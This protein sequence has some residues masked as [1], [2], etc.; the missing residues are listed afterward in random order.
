MTS[1]TLIQFGFSAWH[2]M[3]IAAERMLLGKLP[4]ERGVYCIRCSSSALKLGPSDIVYFGKAENAAGI[5]RRIRQYFHPGHKN[6]TSIR[7]KGEI[8]ARADFELAWLVVPF[9]RVKQMEDDLIAKFVRAYGARPPWNK[10][11]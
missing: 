10:R 5:R 1:A 3:T 2:P 6:A 4:P 8:S 7:I 9:G 11:F